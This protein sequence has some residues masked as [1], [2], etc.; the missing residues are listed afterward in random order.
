MMVTS[1]KINWERWLAWHPL[2][3]KILPIFVVALSWPIALSFEWCLLPVSRK[4]NVKSGLVILTSTNVVTTVFTTTAESGRSNWLSCK[5]RKN[6][7]QH[8]G[9]KSDQNSTKHSIFHTFEVDPFDGMMES[10][11]FKL[12]WGWKNQKDPLRLW[13]ALFSSTTWTFLS[14]YLPHV[15][16]I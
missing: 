5:I 1:T 11:I 16:R 15:L 4:M 7:F 14:V 9:L 3:L 13:K 10:S 8:F 12:W 2:S 6:I